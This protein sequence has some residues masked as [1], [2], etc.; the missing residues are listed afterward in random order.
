L[1][2]QTGSQNTQTLTQPN[3]VG[4]FQ[5]KNNNLVQDP[6]NQV[7]G[8]P[9]IWGPGPKSLG[10]DKQHQRRLRRRVGIRAG[11]GEQ[12]TGGRRLSLKL[13]PCGNCKS[14]SFEAVNPLNKIGGQRKRGLPQNKSKSWIKLT[15]RFNLNKEQ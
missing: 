1:A 6:R 14:R 9:R 10:Q 15:H 7:P 2:K 5:S 13:P 4:D 8:T 3:M 12:G 11:I